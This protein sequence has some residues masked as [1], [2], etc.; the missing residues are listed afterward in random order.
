M[1]GSLTSSGRENIK[2]RRT[3]DTKRRKDLALLSQTQGNK[4]MGPVEGKKGLMTRWGGAV[5]GPPETIIPGLIWQ[6]V[7]EKRIGLSY[8]QRQGASRTEFAD[9]RGEGTKRDPRGE[10]AREVSTG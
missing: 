3:A 6:Y 4:D 9:E 5:G 10:K 2:Q 7:W 8:L 1:G